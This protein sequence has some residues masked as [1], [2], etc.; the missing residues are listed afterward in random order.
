M[1]LLIGASLM[2]IS[3]AFIFEIAGNMIIRGMGVIGLSVGV[4]LVS[5]SNELSKGEKKE[6][7]V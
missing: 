2:I 5:N 7:D 4:Y 3:L 1:K 6:W